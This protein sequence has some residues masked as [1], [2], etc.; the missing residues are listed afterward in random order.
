M[1][2]AYAASDVATQ[3]LQMGVDDKQAAYPDGFQVIG[4]SGMVICNG[5]DSVAE[6]LDQHQM[7]QSQLKSS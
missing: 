6:R 4:D 1:L 7:L 2:L 3:L 5:A